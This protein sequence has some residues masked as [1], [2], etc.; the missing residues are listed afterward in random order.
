MHKEDRQNRWCVCAD[1]NDILDPPPAA[2]NVNALQI[3]F[4]HTYLSLFITYSL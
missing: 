4:R 2:T 1:T 3:R